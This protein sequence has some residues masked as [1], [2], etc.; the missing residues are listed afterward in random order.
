MLIE[1]SLLILIVL[2]LFSIITGASLKE[3]SAENLAGSGQFNETS[4]SFDI[5]NVNTFFYIDE[6][7]GALVI[8]IT[9][10]VLACLFGLQIMGS[11]LSTTSVRIIMVGI[12]YYG[13][14]GVFSVLSYNLIVS[15]EIVGALIYIVLTIMF[16]IGILNKI[17][18]SD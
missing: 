2:S 16:T 12:S 18:K 10:M 11:G 6:F 5:S 9:I 4:T 3:V 13:V 7:S 15:I 8:I 1:I 14:W 17:T